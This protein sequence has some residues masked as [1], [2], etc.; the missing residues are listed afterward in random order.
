MEESSV[1]AL[2]FSAIVFRTP[3]GQS[4][5]WFLVSWQHEKLRFLGLGDKKIEKER[6]C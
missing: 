6:G 5:L 4:S 2:Q 1:L 3:Q